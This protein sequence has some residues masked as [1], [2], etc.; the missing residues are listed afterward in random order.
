M[1]DEPKHVLS[2]EELTSR[3]TPRR[4]V[5]DDGHRWV[6]GRPCRGGFRV[7]DYGAVKLRMPLASQRAAPVQGV[8]F[9]L[10]R[11]C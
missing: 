2:Y 7:A 10:I 6:C 8:N 4:H 1:I 3:T 11:G 9:E 5:V